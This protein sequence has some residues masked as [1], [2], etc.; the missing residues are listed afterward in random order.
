MQ[1]D[2]ETLI[3]VE[4]HGI[5]NNSIVRRFSHINAIFGMNSFKNI[6]RN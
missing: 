2:A 3:Y 6:I 1:G 5:V 4:K